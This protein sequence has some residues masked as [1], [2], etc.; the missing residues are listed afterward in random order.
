M[1]VYVNGD[2]VKALRKLKKKLEREG[3]LRAMKRHEAFVRPGERRRQK[4]RKAAGRAR[5]KSG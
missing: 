2:V 5:K 3:V 4:V 1:K